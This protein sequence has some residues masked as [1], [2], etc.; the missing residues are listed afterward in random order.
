[1]SDQ[2]FQKSFIKKMF[3]CLLGKVCQAVQMLQ[4]DGLEPS[5]IH[6][7]HTDS[8]DISCAVKGIYQALSTDETP[9]LT[10][11]CGSRKHGNK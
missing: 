7:T 2:H 8:K 1:M 9:I 11:R 5:R 10:F 4:S 6:H 3:M